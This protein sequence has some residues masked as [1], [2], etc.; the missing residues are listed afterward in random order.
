MMG[1]YRR[2]SVYEDGRACNI[3]LA[4]TGDRCADKRPRLGCVVDVCVG[5]PDHKTDAEAAFP[6]PSGQVFL[7]RYAISWLLTLVS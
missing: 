2:D 6:A 5:Q 3:D 1:S 7:Q 4:M